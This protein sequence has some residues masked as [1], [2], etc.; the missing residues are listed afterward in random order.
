MNQL[1]HLRRSVRGVHKQTK[2]PHC[3]P[4][5]SKI[6]RDRDFAKVALLASFVMS[7]VKTAVLIKTLA[8]FQHLKPEN[9][10]LLPAH[11]EENV[12]CKNSVWQASYFPKGTRA[13]QA[14][15]VS[16]RS[17]LILESD[18]TCSGVIFISSS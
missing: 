13:L 9:K 17:L 3:T 1:S 7:S 11:Q 15:F 5:K 14:R 2:I 16:V 12:H 18:T 4:S 10:T 8:S 6:L